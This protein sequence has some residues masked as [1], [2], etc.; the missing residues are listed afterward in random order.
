VST[1]DT[2]GPEG[3]ALPRLHVVTNDE[4]LARRGWRDVASRVLRAGGASLALHVRGPDTGPLALFGLVEA[5]VGPSEETGASLIV[6][7]RVDVALVTRVQGVHLG[8]RSLPVE[9]A[10]AV[11]GPARW[12]GVS[13]HGSGEPAAVALEGAD[14]AFMGTIHPTASH[15][16][17]AGSGL[18]AL[19]EAVR[20]APGLPVV[21]IGGIGPAEA[22]EVAGTGA[23]GV[24]AIRGVWDAPDPE[25]A[26]IRYLEALGT[27]QIE[28][29]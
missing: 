2:A 17:I 19:E 10:R 29:R 6:N 9:Q 28:E 1:G 25:A 23:W 20:R 3:R 26:V 15:P 11:L 4:V 8:S 5:L 22:A 24:A 14:Y 16:G 21:G 13:C 27:W 18:A 12:I 7:D